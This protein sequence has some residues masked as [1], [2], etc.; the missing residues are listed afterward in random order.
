MSFPL[1]LTEWLRAAARPGTRVLLGL[2]GGVDSAM[3]LAVL[4][5]L[6]CKVLCVTF[7]N[8][9][10]DEPGSTTARDG[11]DARELARSLGAEH[12]VHDLS[13]EFTSGVISPFVA[14]YLAA[15][16]PNPCVTCNAEVRF[17]ALIRL[18]A[19]HGCTLAATGHYARIGKDESGRP[20][21]MRGVDLEKDQ[22]YFLHRIDPVHFGSLVFPLGWFRKPE[23]RQAA[24]RLKLPLAEK[25]ESQEICFLPD[26]DRSH[27][28]PA[29]EAALVG[30]GDIVDG[31]GHVLGRHRG[32]IHYTV[33]QRR[34]LGI[35]ASEPL[36]VL[37]LNANTSRLVVGTR[38]E[39]HKTCV[40][41]DRFH[42]AVS[43]FPD[44]GPG[45]ENVVARIRHRHRG[46][47][48][49]SWRLDGGCLDVGL[50]EPAAGVA[51]G[52]SLVLYRGDMVLGGGRILAAAD[53]SGRR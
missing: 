14:E 4:Q 39:L 20:V 34:G 2:S 23:V 42:K 5:A 25:A 9:A 31:Q 8:F 19:E 13:G 30:P 10:Q 48:V 16:T 15:R 32:L 46:V 41:T 6:E 52:Q 17:P 37:E 49:E 21:L 47:R 1:P 51:P 18:A 12:F 33:G 7:R 27:L 45:L 35:A 53:Q 3:A 24:A 40:R 44:N 50:A 22:S 38:S 29:A 43:D 26:D 36:Y 28:F 11:Q